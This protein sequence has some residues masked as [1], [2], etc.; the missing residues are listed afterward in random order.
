MHMFAV[1]LVGVQ[2]L[3]QPPQFMTLL[4]AV[5]QPVLAVPQ[6]TKFAL[7]VQVHVPAEQVG[8]P[9]SVLQVW[10]HMP[11]WTRLVDGLAHWLL[12]QSVSPPVH[13]IAQPLQLSGSLVVSTHTLEQQDFPPGHGV[14]ASQVWVHAPDGLHTSPP[15]QSPMVMHSTHWWRFGSHFDLVGLVQSLPSLQPA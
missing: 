13:A 4:S 7:Q 12:Q 1:A 3:P 6:W 10:P 14:D 2:T 11:Q 9:L 15:A 8:V 5:S